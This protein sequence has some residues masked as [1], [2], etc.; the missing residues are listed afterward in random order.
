MAGEFVVHCWFCTCE[1]NAYEASFCNH[2]DPSFI[3]PF[4]LK[5]GCDTPD[6]YKNKILQSYPQDLLEQKLLLESRTSL[7]LGE[8][9]VR[10]GKISREHLLSAIDA[11]K[12]YKKRIGQI[13]ITMNLITEDELTLYL[14]EQKGIEKVDL[15]DYELD[16]KLVDKLGKHFCLAQKIIPLELYRL[17]ENVILRFVLYSP[18]DFVRIRK[19]GRL[20]HITLIPHTSDRK[21]IERL[22]RQIL[23]YEVLVLK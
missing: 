5:C 13:F 11:Q 9:L 2:I 14:L 8:I 21:D 22:L 6:D 1:F 23:D 17:N 20:K 18:Q 19:I 7:K 12:T 16:L 15:K 3:C 10:A 4:C